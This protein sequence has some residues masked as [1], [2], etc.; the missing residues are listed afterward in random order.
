M[1]GLNGKFISAEKVQKFNWPRMDKH[2]KF[3]SH[4]YANKNELVFE[5]KNDSMFEQNSNQYK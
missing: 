1:E 5:K 3:S 2:I 4:N